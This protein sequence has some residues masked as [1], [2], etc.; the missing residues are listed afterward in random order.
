MEIKWIKLMTDIFDHSKIRMIECMPEA[1][2]IIVIWFK[3]LCLAGK[4][5]ENGLLMMTS[6]IPFTEE[7]LSN[8]FNRPL[9]VTRLAL[10]TFQKFGM[11]EV[12]N[13]VLMVSNWEKHQNTEGLEK[14]RLQNKER[15]RNRREK[16]RLESVNSA[17]VG[18]V[19]LPSRDITQ[20]NKNK[21]KNIDIYIQIKNYWNNTLK[22]LPYIV[23]LT[24]DREKL[25]QKLLDDDFT[26]DD[27]KN[28]FEL[29]ESSDFLCGRSD[30]S[31][32]SCNFDWV[33]KKSNFIKISEGTYNNRNTRDEVKQSEWVTQ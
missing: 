5:N 30:K 32:G 14:I 4:A 26:V 8:Y 12:V 7:M 24:Q 10:N 22:S 16:L 2:T 6:D 25:I 33:L 3:L 31:W 19:T 18:H 21:N 15:Q 13:D 9:T 29:V 17:S 1:D 23:K 27:F 11:I 20:Q 28:V